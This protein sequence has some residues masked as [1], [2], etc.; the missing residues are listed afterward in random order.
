MHGQSNARA[1]S[2]FL[3]LFVVVGG[4]LF[5]E[6]DN[7]PRPIVDQVRTSDKQINSNSP[8]PEKRPVTIPS[9]GTPPAVS[10][11]IAV[12]YRC[13]KNGRASFSD[14]P[15]SSSEKTVSVSTSEKELPRDH[16]HELSKLKA[17]ASAMESER[18]EREKAYAAATASRPASNAAPQKEA[19]CKQID[20]E[21]A[22]VDSQLRRPHSGQLGDQL[23]A[24]RKELT[25]LRFSIGC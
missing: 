10:S 24:R 8:A 4:W 2:I 1:I 7:R 22:F 18:I 12:T 6:Y 11:N 23:T 19:R 15:C 17:T 14:Q 3:A 20:D 5:L 25:D 21:I 9:A 13:D 16:R